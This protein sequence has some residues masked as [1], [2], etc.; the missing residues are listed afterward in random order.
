VDC[1]SHQHVI[2][3]SEAVDALGGDFV[4]LATPELDAAMDALLRAYQL[5][6]H[7]REPRVASVSMGELTRKEVRF[8]GGAAESAVWSYLF[9]T[10]GVLL[11]C[12]DLP[13]ETLVQLAAHVSKQAKEIEVHY[14]QLAACARALA[15]QL[16]APSPVGGLP[17]DVQKLLQTAAGHDAKAQE[18]AALRQNAEAAWLLPGLP[19]RYQLQPTRYAWVRNTQ[20]RGHE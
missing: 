6:F 11:Q 5:D 8:Y 20:P 7:L 16:G 12:A 17:A 2:V 4:E 15:Q 14:G 3:R 9:E 13:A 19:R 18:M 1:Y 10:S